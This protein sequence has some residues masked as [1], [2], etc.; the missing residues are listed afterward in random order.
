MASTSDKTRPASDTSSQQKQQQQ[1]QQQQSWTQRLSQIEAILSEP[2]VLK[3]F[4]AFLES[5]GRS[6]GKGKA[7]ARHDAA[8]AAEAAAAASLL[9]SAALDHRQRLLAHPQAEQLLDELL[10]AAA[11]RASHGAQLSLSMRSSANA[12]TSTSISSAA[13]KLDCGLRLDLGLAM[14]WSAAKVS[15][16]AAEPGRAL[17]AALS[18]ANRAG[19]QSPLPIL[20]GGGG[21]GAS[22]GAG[23][24]GL[25]GTAALMHIQ[26]G[27]DPN[28][29]RRAIVPALRALPTLML[30]ERDFIPLNNLQRSRAGIVE[31][32]RCR[33][34]RKLYVLKSMLK[35]VARREP[36]RTSPMTEKNL[37]CLAAAESS[38]AAAAG[39]SGSKKG[40]SAAGVATVADG[41][42]DFTPQICAAFQSTGSLHI[43]MEYFPAGDLNTFLESAGSAASTLDAAGS[44][45]PGRNPTGGLLVEEWVKMYAADIVA[46]VGWVHECG[47]AHRDVKPSNFLM[48]YTGHLK[49]C[50][51]STAAPVSYFEITDGTETGPAPARRRE[52]RVLKFHCREPAGT[53][54]Y[55]APEILLYEEQRLAAES[56]W[57]ESLQA[58]EYGS[59][60]FSHS[61][62]HSASF[63]TSVSASIMPSHPSANSIVYTAAT[64][65]SSSAVAIGAARL[66]KSRS[67]TL[68]VGGGGGG[69]PA[70]STSASLLPRPLG[71]ES[72]KKPLS[73][74]SNTIRANSTAADGSASVPPGS[75][76]SSATMHGLKDKPSKSN[77]SQFADASLA[78]H[79]VAASAT[80]PG[81]TGTDMDPSGPGGYGPEVD[82]WSVGVVIYEMTYGKLPFWARDPAEAFQR[83]MNHSR[84]L[85]LDASVACSQDLRHLIQNLI[86]TRTCRLG[87]DST[88]EVKNHPF[89]R[90]IEWNALHQMD[91]PFVPTVERVDQQ[92]PATGSA[93][94]SPGD[95]GSF[96]QEPSVLHSPSP[97]VWRSSPKPG[98]QSASRNAHQRKLSEVESSLSMLSIVSPVSFS[99]MYQGNVDD[100]PA[101]VNE[102]DRD[103]ELSAMCAEHEGSLRDLD[104]SRRKAPQDISSTKF[105]S[106]VTLDVGTHVEPV[107]KE[108]ATT[109]QDQAQ[110]QDAIWDDIDLE[111]AGFTLQPHAFNF[112]PRSNAAQPKQSAATPAPSGNKAGEH[113]AEV[114]FASAPAVVSLPEQSVLS[115]I[116]E[117]EGQGASGP[118]ASTPFV[119]RMSSLSTIAS[120]EPGPSPL[121][122]PYSRVPAANTMPR[123]LQRR[124]VEAAGWARVGIDSRFV[125]P[126]RKTS[127]PNFSS[128]S[129]SGRGDDI[130]EEGEDGCRGQR[131]VSAPKAGM[132]SPYPFPVTAS[133]R[134]SSGEP[135]AAVAT[136][137]RSGSQSESARSRSNTPAEAVLNNGIPSSGSDSRFSGGSITKREYSE[138]EAWD[139]MMKAVQKSAKKKRQAEDERIA[140]SGQV[141]VIR[142]EDE[143]W[144]VSQSRTGMDK[145]IASPPSAYGHTVRPNADMGE[146]QV[147]GP[148][149]YSSSSN[150]GMP[151]WGSSRSIISDGAR[152]QLAN[153]D[154]QRADVPIRTSSRP[155]LVVDIVSPTSRQ[156]AMEL[157]YERSFSSFSAGTASGTEFSRVPSRQSIASTPPHTGGGLPQSISNSSISSSGSLS[158]LDGDAAQ[159]R[160]PLRQRR[161]TR[162]LLIKAQERTTPS[163]APRS[164]G[165]SLTSAFASSG[166]EA[167]GSMRIA[168]ARPA[169]VFGWS[170]V[171]GANGAGSEERGMLSAP[172]TAGFWGLGSAQGNTSSGNANSSLSNA[173]RRSLAEFPSAAGSSMRQHRSVANV[174]TA[175]SSDVRRKGS[176]EILREYSQGLVGGASAG[177]GAS[178]AGGPAVIGLPPSSSLSSRQGGEW[179][180][181]MDDRHVALQRNIDEIEGRI[182]KLRLRLRQEE[183]ERRTA[184]SELRRLAHLSGSSSASSTSHNGSNDR[185]DRAL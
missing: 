138:R 84:F 89:F 158:D 133:R 85:S 165:P 128:S 26:P 3:A 18:S 68:K 15:L 140:M 146:Q 52:R 56:S 86:A 130:H 91:P 164:R 144:S 120:P 30:T 24:D 25:R 54:D 78:A 20:S 87:I 94:S 129:V 126:M 34:D 53:C 71:D 77:L 38:G 96:E 182:S 170:S 157:D 27:V 156:R 70:S 137:Q 151:R 11:K 49:L 29:L 107:A 103:E 5:I 105:T 21:G 142:V 16:L 148:A 75:C 88:A 121:A 154:W 59:A 152:H 47:F 110:L 39:S 35:G 6:C 66:P 42:P 48:D 46:A 12:S 132:P 124:A 31:V 45:V 43:V 13:L 83:I 67:G 114:R 17:S 44:A 163:K 111:W 149:G 169:S 22:E 147:V 101:F 92:P 33:L 160:W 64:S 123:S 14:L 139:R 65:T 51:F 145:V 81:T 93:D 80:G 9:H 28:P 184:L 2:T 58:S 134:T 7:L 172:P 4:C 131:S 79:A 73:D 82:W 10:S 143:E 90:G 63:M 55:I 180:R 40:S 175:E 167:G 135:A 62:S 106:A 162:Q 97:S 50:D 179:L 181:S 171:A 109:T 36:H 69:V 32:V 74:C 136:R 141:T 150:P 113:K 168:K 19:L 99:A 176:H 61:H 116:E 119:R 161:S 1:Q 76:S 98:S 37:L 117:A 72:G 8:E 122:T 115:V 153:Y 166:S 127:L 60:S 57:D 178:G 23:G 112:A 102:L 177:S 125:T 104:V 183:D 95:P 155:S 173:R 100:F 41:R 108:T 174:R 118:A 185:L 159:V